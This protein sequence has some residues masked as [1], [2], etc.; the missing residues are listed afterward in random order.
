MSRCGKQAAV[1]FANVFRWCAGVMEVRS[2]SSWRW[3]LL[4]CGV[5]G[6]IALFFCVLQRQNGL[7]LMYYQNEEQSGTPVFAR[8]DASLNPQLVYRQSG[9]PHEL[10]SLKWSGWFFVAFSGDYHWKL[11][12]E[13][14]AKL[15]INE[16]RILEKRGNGRIQAIS[17]DIHLERGLYRLELTY[18]SGE[19]AP[20]L[21]DIWA[22]K[23]GTRQ[24][25]SRYPLF[26]HPPETFQ[27]A[28]RVAILWIAAA[29]RILCVIAF[30][31]SLMLMLCNQTS[32][33]DWLRSWRGGNG[34]NVWGVQP[35][36]RYAACHAWVHL[37]IIAILSGVILFK[38]LGE[39][40]LVTVDADEGMHTRVAQFMAK[41]GIWWDLYSEEGVPYYNKPP[42][43]IWLSAL[44]FRYVGT[45]EWC[46]R[47]WDATFGVL[48]LFVVYVWGATLF[49]EKIVGL[50][51]AMIL[52]GGE[53]F[54]LTHSV[55]TG[56]MDSML[57]FFWVCAIALF[58]QRKRHASFSYAA[59]LCIGLGVLT[60]SV[61][62]FVP[63]VI[64]AGYLLLTKQS[65]EFKT[66]PFWGMVGLSLLLPSFWYLPHFFGNAEFFQIAVKQQI[67]DRVQGKIHH[68][69]IHGPF[70]FVQAIYSGFFPWSLLAVPALG[71]GCWLAIKNTRHELTLL[72]LWIFSVFFGF[73]VS[74][75]KVV[76]YMNPLYPAFAL[77][78]AASGIWGYRRFKGHSRY[79]LIAPLIVIIFAG[80]AA[81]SLAA[82]YSRVSERVEKLPLHLFSDYLLRSKLPDYR[83]VFYRMS[84]ADFDY[85]DR[86]YIERIEQEKSLWVESLDGIQEL[87]R[88]QMP[89]FLMIRADDYMTQPFFQEDQY[90][91]WV[92]RVY[93]T[94]RYPSRVVLVYNHK[95][96]SP[97]FLPH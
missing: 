48:T 58:E 23:N 18:F 73:S 68:P 64:I 46:L 93:Y 76:W 51:S 24:P 34:L 39:R 71:I 47:I 81:T 52:L 92:N 32:F 55:R 14:I 20:H 95:P 91:F 2:Q 74:K 63:L 60:K 77:L 26:Q 36:V 86:Y 37:L 44:M 42:L 41:S 45:S 96:D 21:L 53:D 19:G 31:I 38:N 67:F 40:S 50:L 57:I 75:M 13:G 4:C 69:H 25:L 62:G 88:R 43:K 54:I 61:H 83:V 30:G 22:G 29:A 82:N 12:S 66:A 72:L 80:F 49:S 3:M 5:M 85:A 65:A 33:Y 11:R 7:T 84:I 90:N 35:L 79:P 28:F 78:I 10:N 15:S 94:K 59:G 16:R 97:W 56:V 27:I 9:R 89:L 87:S 70:F 6:V 1:Q 8:R 17:T